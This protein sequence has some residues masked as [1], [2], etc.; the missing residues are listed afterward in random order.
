[1]RS[2]RSLNRVDRLWSARGSFP[3]E[4]KKLK[5]L[6]SHCQQKAKA[7][8]KRICSIKNV[9][10][11]V[12]I[13][14]SQTCYCPSHLSSIMGSLAIFTWLLLLFGSC[15][16]FMCTRGK[17]G[18]TLWIG[19]ERFWVAI[20]KRRYINVYCLIEFNP[21]KWCKCC[22]EHVGERLTVFKRFGRVF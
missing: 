15:S 21:V 16:G 20:L 14:W 4:G 7:R 11:N 9:Y 19:I 1:M 17:G 3:A 13:C 5:R 10:P 2:Q 12:Q 18:M 22:E 8:N 6:H